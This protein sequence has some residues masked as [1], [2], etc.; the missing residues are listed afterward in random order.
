MAGRS[1][2]AAEKI[3]TSKQKNKVYVEK[4]SDLGDR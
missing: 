4:S 1:W 3:G 2:C